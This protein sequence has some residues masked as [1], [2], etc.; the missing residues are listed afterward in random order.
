MIPIKYNIRN[1]RV[2][3]VT[4]LMTVVSTALVVAITVL[5]FGLT[6]GVQ[7]ALR[8]AG[9]EL[10]LVVL[11]KGSTN[12][13]GSS[14][15]AKMAREIANLPGIE[16]DDSGTP[17]CST[18]HVTI[19][20]KPRRGGGG[21]VNLIVRGLEPSGRLLRP[22]FKI[23][24]GRDLKPGVNEAITSQAM[25]RRFENLGLNEQLEINKVNFTIVGFFEADGSSAESEVW[26]ALDDLTGARRTPGA[27]SVVNLRCQNENS[28]DQLIDTIENDE[29]FKLK[30]MKETVY[31]EEQMSA[32]IFTQFI[33]YVIGFFMTIGA[34]FAAANTMYSA[35][36]SRARE[37]GTLRA[38]GFSRANILT[39]F[40][41]ESVML[42]LL[43]GI[44]GC[45]AALPFNGYSDGTAN[46]ATFSEITFS[47]Q[48]GP[49][50][51]VR[52]VLMALT[53]GLL[54]G[55]FPAIRAVRM[56][57]IDALRQT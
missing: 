55:L 17:L 56:R 38:I 33:G 44:L 16:K 27:I 32:S 4:T 45:L 2:R 20:T 1:L 39:S 10:D 28:R 8:V 51:F 3:W 13:T 9:D 30:P 41:I 49:W 22:K 15:D 6:D 46:W 7:R 53:M 37:I 24:E 18:E 54:G 34:M 40:L 35:V 52:G 50:V 26:T 43:G 47:F 11:R 57:I 21:T 25:A 14:V 5:T 12:E 29:R 23:V 31:F 36:A 48:F 19:L 42:C